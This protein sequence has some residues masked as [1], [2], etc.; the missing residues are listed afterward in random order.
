MKVFINDVPL[1]IIPMEREIDREHYDLII[2]AEKEKIRFDNLIDDVL[3]RKG[4][5]ADILDFYRF[6]SADKNKK[7]D[8]LACKVYDYA[9]VIKG[10]KKEFKIVEAAGGIVTKKDKYLF[11][12]R[13]KKWDLPKG[14][15]EKK[16]KVETAAV[17]E[18]EEE[19]NVQVELGPK[20]CKTWH[21][22][23]RN[24]KNHLKKT[25]WFHMTLKE[26]KKMKPQKEEGIEKVIWVNKVELRTVLLT[27][28]RSIRYVMKKF[29]EYQ[30]GLITVKKTKA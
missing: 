16:E 6:L 18:V 15:L 14:K 29:H 23:T 7:L 11:I 22:Y 21:T 20:V 12:Y 26:D 19:C 28:Y 1:Y 4:S 8:S 27:T 25:S 10:F 5:L 24:G 9:N 3:I 2:D 13:L 30:E 17:R